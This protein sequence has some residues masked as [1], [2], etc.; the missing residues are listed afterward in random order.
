MV[1]EFFGKVQSITRN[2]RGVKSH[3]P[4]LWAALAITIITTTGIAV[5][6]LNPLKTDA[7]AMN[8][9]DANAVVVCAYKGFLNR[10]P[11]S[12]GLTYWKERYANKNKLNYNATLLGANLYASKEG[13]KYENLIGFDKFLQRTYL[14]CLGRS[15]SSSEVQIWS[16]KHLGGMSRAQIF[17]FIVAAG[18]KPWLIPKEETCV[19]YNKKQYNK[20]NSVN[21]LCKLN[22]AGNTKDVVVEKIPESSIYVNKAWATNIKNLRFAA[23]QQGNYLV[24]FDDPSIVKVLRNVPGSK[25]SPGSHRSFADQTYLFNLYGSPRAARPGNSM[26]EWGLAMDLRCAGKDGKILSMSQNTKC[27]TWM[28]NNAAKYGVYNLPTEPWHWSSNGH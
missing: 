1:Q 10:N 14:S 12:N 27:L 26:H 6:N 3:A 25:L 24:A 5:S 2:A 11:D 4:K 20:W 9:K 15:A 18:D 21:P 7:T 19:N 17:G 28:R 16:T 8:N 23:A 22:S 13:Q